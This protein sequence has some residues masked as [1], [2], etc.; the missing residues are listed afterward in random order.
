MPKPYPKELRDDVVRVALKHESRGVRLKDI[1]ADFAITESCLGN[2]LA[3]AAHDGNWQ[4]K[5]FRLD[6]SGP[7]KAQVV[8]H[9]GATHWYGG[10]T[11]QSDTLLDVSSPVSGGQ[12]LDFWTWYFIEDGWDYGFVEALVNGVW[13]TIPL[14]EAGGGVV[15][16]NTDPQG[17]NT[18]GNGLT[19]TSGGA[20]FVDDPE[21]IHVNAVL[22][23]NTTDVRFRY[24][25]DAA[26]LDTGWF[27]DD[28]TVGGAPAVL[29]G[30]GWVETDGA[31]R[32]EWSVQVVSPCD[33]T[34][35]ITSA[36]ESTEPGRWVYRLPGVTAGDVTTITQA[37]TSCSTQQSY[38]VVV[39][40]LTSG[41]IDNLDASYQ[42][43]VTNTAA[44]GQK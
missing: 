42:L 37:F 39:S 44:K 32:N 12:T 30:D 21:Y 20:Y 7:A 6:F 33:L 35:G 29:S 40:N 2:W 16:T 1:A 3:Q 13:K 31:Q 41:V 15:T 34:P 23:P 38:T 19:G 14:T 25:T 10:A 27:V 17:N 11:S 43:R 4:D 18:E 36:G 8:P 24:S 28:V 9:S 26:Y 5:T 22:P